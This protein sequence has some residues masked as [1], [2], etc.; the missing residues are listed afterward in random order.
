MTIT[1]L[2]FD[3]IDGAG[4]HQ[5]IDL[6]SAALVREGITPIHLLEPSYGP[7]G[8]EVRRRLR[9]AGLGS[10]KE[11]R[12][13]FTLD[14]RDHVETKIKPLLELIRSHAGFAILQSRSYLA[15]AAYQGES[16]DL[17]HL[18]ALVE[19]QR[20]FAP[21][22]DVILI[23]DLPVA[24]AIERL[25]RV[26]RRDSLEQVAI[27]EKARSRYVQLA[28]MYPHCILIDAAGSP[29]KVAARVRDAVFGR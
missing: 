8:Q 25:D 16:E 10:F 29:G 28:K 26:G 11:Q 5:Q 7:H 20:A 6:A 4:K 14:R 12:E 13:L 3:G 22:P 9:D 19:E 21:D 17:D 2:A 18:T 27:L 1:Y 24:A 15:A 23:L